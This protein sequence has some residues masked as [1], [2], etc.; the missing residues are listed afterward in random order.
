MANWD[1][2]SDC[3]HLKACRRLQKIARS[4]GCSFGRGCNE[5]CSAYI[6]K[7]AGEYVTVQEAVDYA[8]DGV[9]GIRGGY[10]AY[11]VYARQDF[12]G[13]TRTIGEILDEMG[14]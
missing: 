6:S 12:K 14:E 8:I 10:N 13:R 9:S 1:H 2:M 4:K 11:D 7:D 3:I 5:N